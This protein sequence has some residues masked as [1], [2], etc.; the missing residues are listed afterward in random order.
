MVRGKRKMS[1]DNYSALY[2]CKARGPY[3]S[4]AL[5]VIKWLVVGSRRSVVLG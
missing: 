4:Q 3:T 2:I 1:Q 5:H